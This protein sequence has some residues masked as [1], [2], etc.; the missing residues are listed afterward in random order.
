MKL[1]LLLFRPD[2]NKSPPQQ[3]RMSRL[4][5]VCGSCGEG[6]FLN[7]LSFFFLFP[8][9]YTAAVAFAAQPFLTRCRTVFFFFFFPFLL[10]LRQSCIFKVCDKHTHGI[11][12]MKLIQINKLIIIRLSILFHFFL[13]FDRPII[14][15]CTVSSTLLL[16]LSIMKEIQTEIGEIIQG[17]LRDGRSLIKNWSLVFKVPKFDLASKWM[18][19]NC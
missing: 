11:F 8:E 6:N 4:C 17:S 15:K 3:S 12:E 2:N 9:C 19:P 1:L 18:F 16:L 13:Q 5:R 7:F 10:L 14:G